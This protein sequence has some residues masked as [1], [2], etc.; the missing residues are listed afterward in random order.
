MIK[1]LIVTGAAAAIMLSSAAGAF[2]TFTPFNFGS[3][4]NIDISNT[5]TVTNT[6]STSA[7][8]GNNYQ[9]AKGDVEYG[10]I[11]TG[12]ANAGAN[13][14]T[15]LNW[16]QFDCGCVLGLNGNV[17]SLDLDLSNHGTV[18]NNI[19]TAANSGGNY[20]TAG[21]MFWFGGE[22]EHS[23]ITTG[24]AGASSVIQNVVNTN[25]FGTTTP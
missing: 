2:A 15:Q 18:T 7:N 23:S 9:T 17:H 6:V 25:M 19:A 20:Q 22:V 11:T 4:A 3:S 21:G 8:T 12:A 1:K 13:V 14:M 24:A 5:G 10:G 16:N